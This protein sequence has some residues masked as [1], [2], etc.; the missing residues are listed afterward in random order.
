MIKKTILFIFMITNFHIIIISQI[1][2]PEVFINIKNDK[3]KGLYLQLDDKK[4]YN[5]KKKSDYKISDFVN[6]WKGDDSG[7]SFN[8]ENKELNGKMYIGLIHFKD[9]KY[10][11]PV[12]RNRSIDIKKG[13]SH[14]AIKKFFG[15]HYDMTGWEQ[16]GKSV[17]G[18]RMLDYRG[19]IVFNGIIGF[20]VTKNGY[21]V[22]TTIING[23]LI[24]L[25]EP[26][27]VTISYN[28]NLKIYSEII[29]AG[30]TYKS[31]KIT[32]KHEVDITNLQA[33]TKYQ[34][35]IKY[36]S[37]SQIFSFKTAP[38]QGSRKPFVFAYA[39]DSRSGKGGGERNMFGHNGYIVKKI[40]SLITQKNAAFMQ[41]TG[42]L[43][44]GYSTDR[45]DIDM[46]YFVYKNTLSP[47]ARYFPVINAMGNHEAVVVEFVDSITGKKYSVDKFP[48]KTE[49]SEKIFA[50]NFVNYKNGP[51]SEDGAYYDINKSKT[52]FP[53][54]KEN[55]FYYTYDN[56]GVI[57]LNSNY[58]YT[59][60]TKNMATTSGNIHGYIMDNQMKWL[61]ETVD[62]FEKNKNI[63]HVFVTVHTPPFPN[64]GHVSDD[65]YYN[66]DNTYRAHIK[67]KPV[68]KGIIERRDQLLDIIVNK[69]KKIVAILTGDE[70]NYC[71]LKISPDMNKYPENYKHKK[72]E[73]NRTIYQINNGA[74]GAPYY[75]QE[76]TPWTENV[77]GFTTQ[78]AVVLFYVDN[79]NI[80]VKVFNPD[81]LELIEE[82]ALR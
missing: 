78:N 73:I 20:K 74:A 9:S 44:A 75:A 22:D 42:D 17:I 76:K 46:Q 38:K 67:G 72:I 66:G 36:G 60:R 16:S 27:S 12:Y 79:K 82:Y 71:K 40:L 50:D 52:N 63:D 48:F 21:E 56:V 54:Y 80:N 81:T 57:V 33:N 59:T 69:N 10:P 5:N 7:L 15:G 31:K 25:L 55:V 1:E 37:N 51:V 61:E 18:Y 64:G 49:S 58:F 53:P 68:R 11:H 65:M 29:I 28:T 24:N 6:A 4:V 30:K 23:P 45:N 43:V 70:H 47:F 62:K 26:N 32:K 8:S 19:N 41:F 2:I 39:S 14:I 13:V 3:E 35:T 77:S 34:Y